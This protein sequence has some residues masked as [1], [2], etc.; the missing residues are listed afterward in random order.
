MGL[1]L[2][3]FGTGVSI[4]GVM[5]NRRN[6]MPNDIKITMDGGNVGE[7]KDNRPKARRQM[8]DYFTTIGSWLII[9]GL[10]LTLVAGIMMYYQ[11]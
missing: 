8:R 11:N 10:V 6:A 1:W 9:G 5:L 7:S 3:I 2:L 4:V